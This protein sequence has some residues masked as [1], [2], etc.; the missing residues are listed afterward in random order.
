MLGMSAVGPVSSTCSTHPA[1][2]AQRDS[3][4]PLA[5]GPGDLL[6]PGELLADTY[7][8]RGKLG[9]G[10]MGQ[11]YE[12][13]DHGLDRR[14]AIK[15]ALRGGS[16]SREARA[17]AVLQGHPS[18]VTVHA[19]GVHRGMEY[20]VMDRIHGVT[21]EQYLERRH[22]EGPRLGLGAVV[23]IGAAIADGLAV[24]HEAGIAHC[25]VKPGNVI[26]APHD[27]VILTDFGIF[28]AECDRRNRTMAWGTAEYMAPEGATCRVASGELFLVDVYALGIV[29]FE[30]V[31]GRRPFE[32]SSWRVLQMQV[33]APVPDP[34]A[35]RPA[36]PRLLATLI[37]EMMAKAP[38]ARPQGMRDIAWQ[39]RRV[40]SALGAGHDDF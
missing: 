6:R 39:L 3:A 33:L 24:V 38:S 21:L 12:A 17:L 34:A 20:A 29:L 1:G 5:Q 37:R 11:V 26:L 36:T 14:V 28:G 2:D 30:M 4:R 35:Q 13:H 27:R 10:G 18:V 16:V 23:D 25:D 31:V 7:E 19:L 22:A 9:E 32:G 8:I 15:V 40:R